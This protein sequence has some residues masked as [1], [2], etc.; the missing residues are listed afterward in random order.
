MKRFVLLL[1]GLAALSAQDTFE[2]ASIRRNVSG[3]GRMMLQPLQPG[4]RFHAINLPLRQIILRAYRLQDFQLE[5][6]PGWAA[7]ERYDITAK[8]AGDVT[9]EQLSVLL[10]NLLKER[11]QLVTHTVKKETNGLALVLARQDGRLGPKL[12]RSTAECAE[13]PQGRGPGHGPQG[14][15]PGDAE[16]GT[17]PVCGMRMSP[18]SLFAGGMPMA[19]LA[20]ALSQASGKLV[21][22]K[23]GLA[24][25]FDAELIYTP[26]ESPFHGPPPPGSPSGLSAALR[27][28]R[29]FACGRAAGKMGTQAGVQKRVG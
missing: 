19:A 5:G 25:T 6:L 11:F 16:F 27:P 10:Q 18:F 4:G 14:P 20:N 28:Q 2:V 13:S 8:A 1:L 15:P 23:T 12:T 17:R 21:T 29:T 7:S 24:G 3:D 26:E 22:D 9:P